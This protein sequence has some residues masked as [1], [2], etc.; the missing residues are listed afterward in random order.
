M[1]NEA[2]QIANTLVSETSDRAAGNIDELMQSICRWEA[3]KR[4]KSAADGN[5]DESSVACR[6]NQKVER[7]LHR[8]FNLRRVFAEHR[9]EEVTEEDLVTEMDSIQGPSGQK[10][11]HLPTTAKIQKTAGRGDRKCSSRFKSALKYCF[12]RKPKKKVQSKAE[13]EQ[14]EEDMDEDVDGKESTS[15]IQCAEETSS[16][17]SSSEETMAPIKTATKSDPLA[18]VDVDDVKKKTEENLLKRHP[19]S[20]LCTPVTTSW[21]LSS[22]I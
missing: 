20:P 8:S 2:E 21:L 14:G 22:Q 12:R 6:T 17:S 11:H 9:G 16:T 13:E 4:T 18:L 19:L 3:E 10:G 7:E 1:E 5:V 15:G